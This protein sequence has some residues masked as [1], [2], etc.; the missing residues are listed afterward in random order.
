MK[1][2]GSAK[3]CKNYRFVDIFWDILDKMKSNLGKECLKRG[4]LSFQG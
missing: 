3:K 1:I 4:L 2:W